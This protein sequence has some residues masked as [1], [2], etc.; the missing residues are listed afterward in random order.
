MDTST[1]IIFIQ[2]PPLMVVAA[3]A[4]SV[5]WWY[6]EGALC[7]RIGV[8]LSAGLKVVCVL[9]LAGA[10]AALT[11]VSWWCLLFWAYL[12]VVSM[13][14][15]FGAIGGWAAMIGAGAL[16][17]IAPVFWGMALYGLARREF[18]Y[19]TSRQ[20][21]RASPPARALPN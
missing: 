14:V 8:S 5:A 17:A 3:A 1:G 10:W 12:M 18:N 16:A 2:L 13:F 11:L 19:A 20:P 15:L 7:R 6:H 4:A 21:L 9:A